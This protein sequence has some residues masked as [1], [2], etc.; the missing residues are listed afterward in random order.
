M[1]KSSKKIKIKLIKS[2]FGRIKKHKASLSG[3]GLRKI[4]QVIEKMIIN[5]PKQWIWSHNRWK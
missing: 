5:N 1:S 3:L 2:R 4:N